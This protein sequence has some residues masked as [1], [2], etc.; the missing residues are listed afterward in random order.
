ME[1]ATGSLRLQCRPA[2]RRPS[3]R[4]VNHDWKRKTPLTAPVV[5]GPC[6]DS[7][8]VRQGLTHARVLRLSS[9]CVWRNHAA[10]NLTASARDF[11]LSQSLSQANIIVL[12][13]ESLSLVLAS[14]GTIVRLGSRRPSDCSSSS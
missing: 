10:R 11:G 7:G 4:E 5:A 14:L 3:D 9:S 8:R 1:D 13:A 2:A 12:E 6:T